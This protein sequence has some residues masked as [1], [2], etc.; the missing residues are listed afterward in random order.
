MCKEKDRGFSA[1]QR[2]CEYLSRF[3]LPA[4][5]PD[6][7]PGSLAEGL[8]DLEESEKALNFAKEIMDFVKNKLQ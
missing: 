8:P 7:L 4:R 1:L 2:G 3:Y 6:A 5:Y